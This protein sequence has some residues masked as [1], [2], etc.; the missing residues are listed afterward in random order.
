MGLSMK[1]VSNAYKLAMAQHLRQHAYMVVSIGII[2]N[3]AQN[4]A[5]IT[6]EMSYLSN[7]TNLFKGRDVTQQY[8]TLEEN[9][10]KADGSMIFPPENN[11]Y[12]QLASIV[13]ALSQDVL[14]SITVQF[15]NVY[16]LKGL[17]IDFGEYYPTSFTVTTNTD[18]NTY[19]N[20]AETFVTTDN[21]DA[22]NTITITPLSF[23]NGDNKRLRIRSMK[24]G[25][26]IVFQTSDIQKY[27]IT[28]SN[29][30]I[31]TELPQIDSEVTCLDKNRQFNVDDE[32]SFIQ[33]LQTG[34][35]LNTT[36][37]IELA[38]G[39]IE[40]VQLPRTYLTK[41]SSNSKIITLR[42]GD[43]FKAHLTGQYESGNYIHS[44]TAYDEAENVFTEAGLEPDEYF[45]DDVLRNVTLINP[46]PVVSFG[47]ALQLIANASRCALKQDELGRI[48]L[49]PNF[50]NIVEPADLVVTTDS[51][52]DWSKPDNI[53]T[54]STIV[55]ADLTQNFM[56]VDGSMFFIP[57]NSPFLDSGYISRYVAD[58]NGDFAVT[59][60]IEISLPANFTYYGMNFVFGGNP[61]EQFTVNVYDA[62]TLLDSV[63]IIDPTNDYM[64]NH[65]LYGFD[66]IQLVFD[67]GAP[68]NRVILQKVA[69]ANITDYRLVK[70]DMMNEPVGTIETK[71]KAI[72]VKVYTY[73][74]EMQE[75]D[76]ETKTVTQEV[77]DDVYYTYDLN[78]TGEV[79]TFE[80]QLINTL[81]HAERIAEWL[82]N[83][84]SNNVTY[85]VKYRGDPR[86]E[87]T[88]YIFMDSD[89]LNNLQVEVDSHTLNYNGAISGS[90]KLR[91]AINMIS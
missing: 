11:E 18:V 63:V 7:N 77:Q 52:T 37:G 74:E 73:T 62:D 25:V 14:G 10:F 70:Q 46:M 75:V 58:E 30:F 60:S 61:P 48:A 31:S 39:S 24:M 35:E 32:T 40:W 33:Y 55:Y 27:S 29:S 91:R 43:R 44:R 57:E 26:G 19:S 51:Q 4:S 59:P 64:F 6:S 78:P 76:G 90:L 89:V 53:R 36:M 17:T 5:K 85:Q 87:S 88:D 84:Y 3:E 22:V 20:E 56:A 79:I 68:N 21:F 9:V 13:T 38:D 54:G 72:R 66:K 41:W 23:Q 16:D 1:K 67:K 81:E 8:A 50:E 83:Y 2:S 69:F 65:E 71:I 15:D 42:G 86:I 12:F 49:I 80:N 45:I 28:D 34:Q 47:E 82:A